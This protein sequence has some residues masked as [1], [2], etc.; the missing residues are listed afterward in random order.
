MN[1]E[2]AEAVKKFSKWRSERKGIRSKIPVELWDLACDL[3]ERYGLNKAAKPLKLN[4]TELSKRV[5]ERKASKVDGNNT[6]I[7]LVKVAP[8]TF[9]DKV[10]EKP[11]TESRM[12]A[13]LLSPCGYS[14]KL[15]SGI[16]ENSLRALVS[17]MGR[18]Q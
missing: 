18:A 8:V 11:R 12:I 2:I 9:P 17:M 7:Q 10:I 13:E 15:Y 1:D 6:D 4:R 5:E 16:D 3:G 14:I